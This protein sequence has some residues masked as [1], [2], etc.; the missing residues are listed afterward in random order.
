M[1]ARRLTQYFPVPATSALTNGSEP[2]THLRVD[3]SFNE[4]GINYATYQTEPKCYQLSVLPVKVKRTEGAYGTSESFM[5]FSNGGFRVSLQ[6]T[7]RYNARKLQAL[8][9]GLSNHIA[10]LAGKMIDGQPLDE[11]VQTLKAVA[12]SL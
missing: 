11:T 5:M 3:V 7:T 9:N 4:G 2:A 6:P 12:G 1:N 10:V 8:Y